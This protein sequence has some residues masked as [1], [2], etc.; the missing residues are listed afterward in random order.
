MRPLLINFFRNLGSNQRL[1]NSATLL[2][3]DE[4]VLLAG[5]SKKKGRISFGYRAEAYP[6]D[7][8]TE[9]YRLTRRIHRHIFTRLKSEE[10]T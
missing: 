5:G 7:V 2:A 4:V 1:V 10:A 6:E 8:P 9:N 3:V